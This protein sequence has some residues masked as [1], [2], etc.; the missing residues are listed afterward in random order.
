M[1]SLHAALLALDE[2]ASPAAALGELLAKDWR[3]LFPF[4][5]RYGAQ[6]C[7]A[8]RE[9]AVA[10]DAAAA[11][12]GCGALRPPDWLYKDYY[13]DIAPDHPGIDHALGRLRRGH[14]TEVLALMKNPLP[15]ASHYRSLWYEVSVLQGR[16]VGVP[17]IRT[18]GGAIERP[19]LAFCF[20]LAGGGPPADVVNSALLRAE[21]TAVLQ[22][23]V[24]DLDA[25]RSG[26]AD[27]LERLLTGSLNAQDPLFSS[28][29][30]LVRQHTDDLG[31]ELAEVFTQP[32]PAWD[33]AGIRS[34]DSILAGLQSLSA[35]LS[36]E[37]A[38]RRHL[39]QG[40]Q[41]PA[42]PRR[43]LSH[44]LLLR[45]GAVSPQSHP[46]DA[47]PWSRP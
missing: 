47:A 5:T 2:G 32:P 35:P 18:G 38:F 28:T 15:Q 3:C 7:Q 46:D 20:P 24:P 37:T 26:M 39:L 1:N 30:A 11:A 40:L 21:F 12:F 36:G 17:E 29:L 25:H 42:R 13:V 9:Q 45:D 41:S 44:G 34:I 22:H 33:A 16:V 14:V 19:V 27:A 8:L 31:D 4:R 43:F 6:I 23:G 10:D